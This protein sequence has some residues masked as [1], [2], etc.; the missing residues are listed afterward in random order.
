LLWT[1]Y[2]GFQIVTNNLVPI[3]GAKVAILQVGLIVVE[4]VVR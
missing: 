1:T 3:R 4:A 2:A